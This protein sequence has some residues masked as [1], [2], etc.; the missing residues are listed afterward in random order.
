[1][2][3]LMD[4]ELIL[5]LMEPSMLEIGKKINSMGLE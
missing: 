1:M 5:I 2:I 4:M 3:K